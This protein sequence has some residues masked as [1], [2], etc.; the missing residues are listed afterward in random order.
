MGL[1][2]PMQDASDLTRASGIT[3]DRC[4]LSIGHDMSWGNAFDDI[5]HL[6]REILHTNHLS[7][8]LYHESWIQKKP[9]NGFL[10][11]TG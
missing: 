5:Q 10:R 7:P 9:L 8:S 6:M 11:V 4:D 1:T 3:G 2:H